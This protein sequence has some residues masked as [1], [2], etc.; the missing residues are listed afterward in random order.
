MTIEQANYNNGDCA[1]AFLIS[2][3]EEAPFQ[4]FQERTAAITST[5]RPFSPLIPPTWTATT[6]RYIRDMEILANKKP[7]PQKGGNPNADPVSSQGAHSESPE[8][9]PSS[10][11][12]RS[13]GKRATSDTG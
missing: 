11:S 6:L 12:A 4:L 9:N 5:G 7:D 8:I 13:M 10:Q 3:H 2:F 1:V